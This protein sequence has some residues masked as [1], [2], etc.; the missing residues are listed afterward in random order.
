MREARAEPRARLPD[1]CYRALPW[2]WEWPGGAW[3][4]SLEPL[5]PL[6]PLFSIAFPCGIRAF[7]KRAVTVVAR[8]IIISGSHIV[9]LREPSPKNTHFQ[10]KNRVTQ[11]EFGPLLYRF[12]IETTTVGWGFAMD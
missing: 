10:Q 11:G 9:D 12:S 7:S 5:S 4:G 1:A 2:P 3:G 6:S 8:A